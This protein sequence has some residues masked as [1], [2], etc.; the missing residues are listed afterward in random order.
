MGN[1]K[2]PKPA[3]MPIDVDVWKN[4]LNYSNFINAY[5]QYRDVQKCEGRNIL[6]VGPGQGFDKEVLKWRG[7]QVTTFDIDDKLKPDFLGSVHD[8]SMFPDNSFDILIASHVLEHL[9][10]PYLDKALAEIHRVSKFAIIYLPVA[11]RHGKININLGIKDISINF[12]WDLF[13]YFERP[14]G[15]VPKYCKGQHYWEIGLR[16]FKVKDIE[17]RIVR[18]FELI[19]SYRNV[20]WLPSYNF[21]LRS[22]EGVK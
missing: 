16:G 6:I 9:A 4:Q 2:T 10:E 8:L 7:Y 20:D 14:N 17:R 19:D 5:Y 22:I 15:S 12:V 3:V 18:H 13:N 21:V 11:G 1:T